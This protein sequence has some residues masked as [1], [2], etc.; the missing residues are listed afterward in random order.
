MLSRSG[1]RLSRNPARRTM[2]HGRREPNG[3][4]RC[5]GS[6]IPGP[7]PRELAGWRARPRWNRCPADLVTAARTI[8][9]LLLLL[10]ALA[11]AGAAEE[12]R[13]PPGLDTIEATRPLVAVSAF[14]VPDGPKPPA[15]FRV[16]RPPGPVVAGRALDVGPPIGG[17][18]PSCIRFADLSPHSPSLDPTRQR[19]LARSRLE[20]AHDS[21][22]ARS[23][24]LSSFST[25]LPPPYLA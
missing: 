5:T 21:A 22:F 19:A 11:F 18:C 9:R 12:S 7:S 24:A 25:S 6:E 17:L 20:F 2:A 4:R 1:R 15:F 10:V 3:S 13:T 8:L 16:A 14:E 23:G